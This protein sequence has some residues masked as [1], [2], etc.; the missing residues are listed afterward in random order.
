MSYRGARAPRP[1]P[2]PSPPAPPPV[3]AATPA[4]RIATSNQSFFFS[5]GRV[6]RPRVLPPLG[7]LERKDLREWIARMSRDGLAPSSRDAANERLAFGAQTWP[8]MLARTMLAEQIYRAFATLR[9]HP[10][11]R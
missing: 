7:A 11:P 3:A 10:Y 9:G 1:R 8:H 4:A 5:T 6:G 2:S